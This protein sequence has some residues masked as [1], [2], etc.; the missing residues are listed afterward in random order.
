MLYGRANGALLPGYALAA[1]QRLA[2]QRRMR[3]IAQ[4]QGRA[5]RAVRY[6]LR[7]QGKPYQWGATGPF[8]YDC[9]G[10]VQ[11]AWR[12][13]GVA[14][15]RVTYDQY[16]GI[17]KKVPR[18]RLR[19]GDLVLFDGLR[20][21]GMYVGRNHFVHAPRAGRPIMTQPLR[22][23]YGRRYVGAVRPAWPRLPR[24]PTY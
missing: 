4:W 23:Y 16:R 5:D 12:R 1:R 3:L 10:L 2:L 17:R 24:I 18:R 21:V 6:A 22:G 19:P 13:A 8:S 14:I 20:H 15:P 9:S 7:Q 11:R